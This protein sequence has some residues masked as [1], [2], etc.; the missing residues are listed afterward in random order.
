MLHRVDILRP[1]LGFAEQHSVNAFSKCFRVERAACFLTTFS[2]DGGRNTYERLCPSSACIAMSPLW[3]QLGSS[4]LTGIAEDAT[5]ARIPGVTGSYNI[6]NLSPGTYT[7][8]ALLPGFRTPQVT[9][10]QTTVEVS[11]E[12]QQLRRNQ[13]GFGSFVV[14]RPA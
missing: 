8:R 2:Y 7:L 3:A 12:A 4:V 5:Q 6:P 10:T 11:V 13:F 14:I 9:A 1:N